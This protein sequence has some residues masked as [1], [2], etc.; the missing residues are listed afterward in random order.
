MEYSITLHRSL[1]DAIDC[2]ELSD[3][4]F[5]EL[6][7]ALKGYAMEG[8]LPSEFSSK[9]VKG[10]FLSNLPTSDKRKKTSIKNGKKGGAPKGNSNAKK[11]PKNDLTENTLKNQEHSETVENTTISTIENN[12]KQPKKTTHKQPK[13]NLTK[14][15]RKEDFR[16]KLIPFVNEYSKETVRAFFDYWTESGEN[17]QKMLFEFK[18]TFD[19]NLRLANW[20][21]RESFVPKKAEQKIGGQ[22][23]TAMQRN[24]EIGRQL[25]EMREANI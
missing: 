1:F 13:N 25:K 14:E 10:V 20:A 15:E 18:K 4:E 11:Q 17:Q 22:S 16:Q 21:K 2:F 7:M 24:V 5:R 9:K 3:A 6:I 8:V 12:L 19:I 23:V